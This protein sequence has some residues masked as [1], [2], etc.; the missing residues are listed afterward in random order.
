MKKVRIKVLFMCQ[1]NSEHEEF[2]Q[3]EFEIELIKGVKADTGIPYFEFSSDNTFI[4][5]KNVLDELHRKL[6]QLLIYEKG[7]HI[8]NRTASQDF[9]LMRNKECSIK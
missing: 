4:Q 2:G 7:V 1:I 9:L 3:E 5:D 8:R 6:M